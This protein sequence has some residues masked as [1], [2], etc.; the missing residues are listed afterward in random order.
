MDRDTARD[1]LMLAYAIAELT[2]IAA[3]LAAFAVRLYWAG[4]AAAFLGGV[5]WSMRRSMI[6]RTG[7]P[8]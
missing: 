4:A 7:G 6:R 8:Q 1:W 5:T 3:C 2:L